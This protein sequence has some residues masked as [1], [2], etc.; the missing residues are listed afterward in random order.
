[1]VP[2]KKKKKKSNGRG[3]YSEFA[4][5]FMSAFTIRRLALQ[6]GNGGKGPVSKKWEEGAV[7]AEGERWDEGV[8]AARLKECWPG[9]LQDGGH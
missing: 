4:T 1:M 5:N 8:C 2:F 3:I 6:P 7:G 9:C